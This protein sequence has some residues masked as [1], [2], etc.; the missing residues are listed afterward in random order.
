ML[1][2]NINLQPGSSFKR[3][4]HIKEIIYFIIMAKV[5]QEINQLT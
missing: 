4:P 5:F 2:I 3:V 1:S